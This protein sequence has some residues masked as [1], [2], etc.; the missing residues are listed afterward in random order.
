MDTGSKNRREHGA[1]RKAPLL[2]VIA[3]A[4]ALA[5]LA[6]SASGPAARAVQT[7]GV[8]AQTCATKAACELGAPE[9]AAS[10]TTL[11][12]SGPIEALYLSSELNC[13][14]KY[15]GDTSYEFYSPSSQTGACTTQIRVGDITYGPDV[16]PA[17]NNPEPFTA[18]SQSPVQ[19]AGTA[20][21]PLRVTTVVRAGATGI[22]ISQLDSYITG[23]DVYRTDITVRNE[24][25]A[26][27]NVGVYRAGDCYLQ[28]SDVGTGVAD[29]ATGAVSCKASSGR[30]EQ[31]FPLT[32]G[33][34]YFEDSYSTVW[35]RIQA[36]LAFPNTVRATA[37]DNG[38]GLYWPLSIPAGG[39]TVASHLT[40]F[41][42]TGNA[43]LPTTKTAADPEADP[44]AQDSY[45][46]TVRNPNTADATL[47]SITDLLPVGFSYVPGSTTGATTANPSVNGRTLTWTGAFA[48]P[49]GGNV[50]LTFKAKVS[51]VPGLY[52]NEA[53]GVANG[54][55]VV[56]P[57]GPTAPVT[58][59]GVIPSTVGP[60]TTTP[61]ASPLPDGFVIGVD[62]P[63]PRPT[64]APP[65]IA[66]TTVPPTV[67]PTVPP[68]VAPTVAP[69]TAAPTTVAPVPT[70][71]PPTTVAAAVNG[72]QV[73][74]E[75][76]F[77]GT[78]DKRTATEYGVPVLALGILLLAVSRLNRRRASS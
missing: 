60:T 5:P 3:G 23:Q 75:V 59:R 50:T 71:A 74:R 21:D 68:T 39:S 76:A 36:G 8:A 15:A 72:I 55:F 20:A 26:A 51:D 13:Q 64:V 18:V 40:A 41:S 12:S 52:R 67:A 77:T 58:V 78:D 63:T 38:A 28:N 45:T 19:G 70:T 11:T 33:S 30:I 2:A 14:V 73:E 61:G 24:S 17:G 34:S 25:G 31:W 49:A 57:T 46:I 9:Q 10:I 54:S 22:V 56:A 42:P 43:V 1:G 53:G 69:T 48:A 6:A 4:L 29:T 27:L 7:R 44:G 37:V 62:P 65:T 16:I 47:T 32:P 35:S 66:P